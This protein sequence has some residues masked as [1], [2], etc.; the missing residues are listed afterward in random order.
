M[1]KRVSKQ[2]VSERAARDVKWA[3]LR[4]VAEEFGSFRPA[5]E[6]LTR[7]RAVPTIFPQFDLVTKVGGLPI[8]RFNL[9]HGPSAGGKTF[10]AIAMMLSF[11][12]R[13]H[14]VYFIDGERTT[15]ITWLEKAMGDY[16]DHPFFKADKPDTYEQTV[17]DVR[18]FCNKV[19]VLRDKGRLKENTSALIVVDSIRKL[20][21]KDQFKRIMKESRAT[22]EKQGEVRNR[23]AQIKAQMNAAW[24][25][26]LIPLLDA[27]QTGML[28]IAREMKD[29]DNTNPYAKKF[30]T[31][32]KTA[33]GGALF[34]DASL[35]L[36]CSKVK[37]YG[38]VTGTGD[39]KKMVA[40]GDIHELRITKSKVSG[41]EEYRAACRFHISNGV[42]V[43]PGFDRGRDLVELARRFDVIEGTSWLKYK[44][45]KWRNEDLATKRFTEDP[46]LFAQVEA[47]CRALFKQEETRS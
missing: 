37:S 21:P 16:S 14:L 39:Q 19:R 27:T 32:V 17:E 1:K 23:L 7:V 20:V 43:P 35:D 34:Y 24:L 29:P 31:D 25:D 18:H 41:K 33:G 46:I 44:A 28:V 38:K 36:R 47:E 45:M 13:D 40:Y 30:G 12:M 8:E 3:S 10:V 42:F 4:K 22:G 11:L 6:V 5:S 26:E 9:L 15:P 2:P